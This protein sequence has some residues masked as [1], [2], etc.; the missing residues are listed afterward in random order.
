MWRR[1]GGL[2]FLVVL[3]VACGDDAGNPFTTDGSGSSSTLPGDTTTTTAS[4]TDDFFDLSA[5]V[6]TAPAT[7]LVGVD[8]LLGGP[9]DESVSRA[10]SATATDAAI[11][12][13][14]V[15][16]TVWP[17]TG[18]GE[19]LLVIEFAETAQAYA[20]DEAQGGD[21]FAVLLASPLIDDR[22]ITRVVIR[23]R[24]TDEQ[25]PYV[26]TFTAPT[27]AMRENLA[28]GASIP[29]DELLMEIK[30]EGS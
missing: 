23:M 24:G 12:L 29:E 19:S 17:V 16:I 6:A 25:G 1:L 3:V 14:G 26:F 27:A 21:L 28:T 9:A 18:T 10:L 13:T 2:V 22:S 15:D 20:D 30:R 11:D 5:I 7:P 4:G 8:A